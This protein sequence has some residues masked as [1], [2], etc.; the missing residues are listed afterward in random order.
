[1]DKGRHSLEIRSKASAY[2]RLLGGCIDRD[3]NEVGVLDTLIDVGGEEEVPPSRLADNV[4]E[5]GFVDGKVIVGTVPGVDT[6]LVEVYNG[7]C[8]VRALER[9]HGTSRSSCWGKGG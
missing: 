2:P 8:D 5:P 3:E 9:Y 1:M 4:F 7:H 6:S